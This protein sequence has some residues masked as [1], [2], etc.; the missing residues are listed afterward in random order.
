MVDHMSKY[1]A[2]IG[3]GIFGTNIAL[4]LHADGHRIKL[5]ESRDNILKGTSFNNTRR[6]HLGFHYPR[7]LSTAR[8]SFD[9]FESFYK[10]YKDCIKTNFPNYYLIAKKDSKTSLDEYFNFS[11]SLGAPH[12]KVTK[13][14]PSNT[15]NC[16]GGIKCSEYVYDC[17]QLRNL[18]YKEINK[19][20]IDLSISTKVNSIKKNIG[21]QISYDNNSNEG[22]DAIVNCSYYNTNQFNK[23]L[24]ISSEANKYEYTVNFVIDLPLE[25]IGLTIM[26][27]PF[28]TLL[29][30][31]KPGRFILYHVKHSVLKT[32]VNFT[33]PKEW[34]SLKTSPS[35]STD[36]KQLF[37]KTIEDSSFY[38]PILKKAKLVKMLES[39][40]MILANKEASDARPSIINTPLENYLTVFSGKIDHCFSVADKISNY[41]SK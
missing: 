35:S 36:I 12:K 41:F 40:R 2:V 27:G 29:P 28:V 14:L 26:D 25:H 31:G 20:D 21:Y 16:C 1:I 32:V 15:Q 6:V 13:Q 5:I 10:K 23:N 4:K 38:I 33:P 11:S 17:D 22:F 9:G 3:A 30:F 7:D 8:Q 19:T 24:N 18:I 34:E 37:A 39:P